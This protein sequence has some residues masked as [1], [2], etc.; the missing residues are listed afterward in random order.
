VYADGRPKPASA[1]KK[2]LVKLPNGRVEYRNIRPGFAELLDRITTGVTNGA[3]FEDIDRA[4][5]TTRD[6]DDL[7]D[8]C[9]YRKANVRT[10][11]GRLT[12]TDGGTEL[13][14]DHAREYAQRAAAYS[15]DI[16]RKVKD[17]RERLNGK[18]YQGGPRPYGYVRAEDTAKYERTLIV[19]PDEKDEL[20]K[21]AD[22]ILNKGISLRAVAKS[23][24]E[25]GVPNTR[26]NTNWSARTVKEVLTKPAIAGLATNNGTQAPATWEAILDPD[27]W[28]KLCTMLNDPSRRTSD[29]GNEPKWLVSGLAK[30]GPCDNGTPVRATGA[31]G[32]TFY[33][34]REGYHLKRLAKYVDAWV[35]RNITAYISVHGSDILKPEPKPDIDTDKL[36][37]E[38][39]G[40][41][42]RQ[43]SQI[44]MH[45]E[46]LIPDDDLKRT[47]RVIKDRISSIDAQLAHSDRPDPIPEFRRHGETRKIWHDLPIARK[48]AII[49]L[50]ADITILP[51]AL[52]GRAGFDP[53]SVRIVIK[54]TGERLDVRD[55][56][57]T[58]PAAT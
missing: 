46:G 15:A 52:R 39:K 31:T 28:E 44:A 56:P 58:E 55:W 10:A 42:K 54:A 4:F 45:A 7:L 51:S 18:T 37:A 11:S 32:K 40:L 36:K 20:L 3:I 29:I 13:E 43:A 53:N 34:C 27:D 2:K 57:E 16:S 24:R 50:L 47:L 9:Q 17:A 33:T 6:C 8:A 41:R 35:E 14:R 30:C 19:V 38:L 1:W 22:S 23:L 26:G 5:R 48:R 12:I 49:E 21:M 25:R